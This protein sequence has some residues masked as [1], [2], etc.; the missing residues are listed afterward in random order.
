MALGDYIALLEHLPK[1]GAL[2]NRV[3][4][5][6]EGRGN[7]QA[8][9]AAEELRASIDALHADVNKSSAQQTSVYR[10]L[11]EQGEQI[12]TALAEVRATRTAVETTAQ[13]VE[14]LEARIAA[15][16]RMLAVA[17]LFLVLVLTILIVRK[18]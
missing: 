16:L 6:L 14:K 10:Q 13:R 5:L 7:A 12:S 15:Q 18:H 17:M 4:P 2:L 8:S 9:A 3:L 1:V 11:N